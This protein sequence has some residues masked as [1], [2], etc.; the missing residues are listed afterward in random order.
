MVSIAVLEH[1]WCEKPGVFR[2]ALEAAGHQV[3]EIPLFSGA[4]V[5]SASDFDAWIVMGGPMNVEEIDAYPFLLPERQLLA[6]LIIADRPVIGICLGAQ[7]VARAAGARVYTKRPKE[8]GLFH[9]QLTRQAA[10]DPLFREFN[11]PEEVFQWH[12]D[13][14]D[15]P[16]G[17]VHLAR[18][19]RF[20]HQA[21]RL[22]RR[23]YAL[24]FHLEC[25]LAMARQWRTLWTDEVAV[26]PAED[27]LSKFEGKWEETLTRQNDLARKAILAWIDL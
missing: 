20:E 10:Y 23:V 13:T 26:L 6:E 24:Q 7:L 8:I 17:A 15:L 25:N 4:S 14:F 22:G 3:T 2:P 5:P 19:E 21:F 18:S 1:F 9:I 16:A 11:D 12:G 27:R